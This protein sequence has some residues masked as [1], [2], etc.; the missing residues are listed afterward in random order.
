MTNQA[1]RNSDSKWGIII[2][3]LGRHMYRNNNYKRC[4]LGAELGK[5]RRIPCYEDNFAGFFYFLPGV[6]SDPR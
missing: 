4:C 5:S 2:I 6:W 3:Y 1:A